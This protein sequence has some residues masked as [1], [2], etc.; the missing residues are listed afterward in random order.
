LLDRDQIV[1]ERAPGELEVSEV[2][3]WGAPLSGMLRDVLT[4]D[5]ALRLPAGSVLLPQQ[6]APALAASI[7]VDVLSLEAR[8]DHIS[9]EG[10][11]SLVPANSEVPSL[12]RTVHLREPAN[13]QDYAAQVHAMSVALGHLADAMAGALSQP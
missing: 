1:R 3:R 4:Q 2:H 9:F 11:W 13:A 8:G 12:N 6:P 7:T 5:L 10:A